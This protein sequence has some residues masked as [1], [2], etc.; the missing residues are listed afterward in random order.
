[1]S[2]VTMGMPDRIVT[3]G[4]GGVTSPAAISSPSGGGMIIVDHRPRVKQKPILKCEVVQDRMVCQ[5]IVQEE[6]PRTPVVVPE[7]TLEDRL[8]YNLQEQIIRDLRDHNEKLMSQMQDMQKAIDLKSIPDVFQIGKIHD[9]HIREVVT[10]PIQ[11][12]VEKVVIMDPL[13]LV[14]MTMHNFNMSILRSIERLVKS[15]PPPPSLPGLP[16]HT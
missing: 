8:T 6:Q 10:I 15:V 2:I 4:L 11:P 13:M 3:R 14:L 9:D 16:V 1:M 7:I 5:E 12:P